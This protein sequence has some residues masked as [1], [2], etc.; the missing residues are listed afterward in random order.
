MKP[1]IFL[2]H[3][4]VLPLRHLYVGYRCE[5]F[6]L[7]EVVILTI[8]KYIQLVRFSGYRFPT[9]RPN[10]TSLVKSYVSSK[11]DNELTDYY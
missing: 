6:F 7:E 8:I 4:S 9:S 10:L 2:S 11:L 5:H 3:S 1:S